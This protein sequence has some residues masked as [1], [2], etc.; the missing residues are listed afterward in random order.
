MSPE[1]P[2]E[3]HSTLP[4]LLEVLQQAGFAEAEIQRHLMD[5]VV[6]KSQTAQSATQASKK[7]YLEQTTLI[8]GEDAFI[9]RR[10]DTKK[11]LWYLRMYDPRDKKNIVRSLGTIDKSLAR[12][13]AIEIWTE[14][15]Q[16]IKSNHK[17]V[18]LTV[19]QLCD[20]YLKE[21]QKHLTDIPRQGITPGTLKNKQKH[22]RKWQEFLDS[23]RLSSTPVDRIDPAKIDG[24]AFGRW[25]LSRPQSLQYKGRT[26]SHDAINGNISQIRR[27]YKFAVKKRYLG[28]S[29]VPD[30]EYL[31]MQDDRAYKRDIITK[32]EYQRLWRWMQDKWCRGRI[33]QRYDRQAKAWIPCSEDVDGAQWKRDPSV[34][35]EDLCRRVCF[36][37]LIGIMTNVGARI[38]EYQGLR[39]K[40]IAETEHPDPEIRSRCL[41]LTITP[42]NSKTGKGRRIVA[43]I[44]KRVD[45]IRCIYDQC[46]FEHHLDPNSDALFFVDPKDGKPWSQRKLRLLLDEVLTGSGLKTGK[47]TD[48]NLTLYFTRHQYATWRLR[49]GVNRHLLAKNMGTSILQLEK[50]YGHIDTE[51]SAAELIKGQGYNSQTVVL[52][53]T[54][55][56]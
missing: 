29:Q 49:A 10:A 2:Q 31:K 45:A 28:L 16:K 3:I 40:D 20:R 30:V 37:K 15:T 39:C 23:L 8:D 9:Y 34:T 21:E 48:K 25:L 51:I 27:M 11:K 56:A 42:A 14:V 7:H 13:K 1:D 26:R 12:V 55:D 52:M 24:D 5:L 6:A 53:E 19:Q 46:G 4:S 18:S 54:E 22:L 17:I 35:D 32:D 50:T 43:P 33:P 44:R 41:T 47:P 38:K 36:E